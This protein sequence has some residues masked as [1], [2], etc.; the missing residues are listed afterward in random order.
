MNACMNGWMERQERKGESGFPGH[1][2]KNWMFS[3]NVQLYFSPILLFPTPSSSLIILYVCKFCNF[4][5]CHGSNLIVSQGLTCTDDPQSCMLNSCPSH[6][7]SSTLHWGHSASTE[8]GLACLT[9]E[10]PTTQHCGQTFSP[11]SSTCFVSTAVFVQ[12]FEYLVTFYPPQ[13]NESADTHDKKHSFH[14]QHNWGKEGNHKAGRKG[15]MVSFNQCLSHL[16]YLNVCSAIEEKG[17]KEK[18][19]NRHNAINIVKDEA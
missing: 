9:D 19:E 13:K 14:K 1:R 11:M 8:C 3:L 2:F 18:K 5:I 17:K 10:W 4:F 6:T 7:S 12:L 15:Q 16:S